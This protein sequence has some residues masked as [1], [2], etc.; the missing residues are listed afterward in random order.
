[1]IAAYSA[2]P[3]IARKFPAVIF[4]TRLQKSYF[5]RTAPV[6]C[7]CAQGSCTSEKTAFHGYKLRSAFHFK[8]VSRVAWI[9]MLLA[10]SLR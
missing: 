3:L 8:S 1:M 4:T 9:V 10:Q 7:H 5:D 2:L 6:Q